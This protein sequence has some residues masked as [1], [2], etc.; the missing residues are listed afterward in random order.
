MMIFPNL[1]KIRI[2]SKI[3]NKIG[4][5]LSNSQRKFRTKYT[6]FMSHQLSLKCKQPIRILRINMLFSQVF[7]RINKTY[8][9]F[10]KCQMSLCLI[11]HCNNISTNRIS[12]NLHRPTFKIRCNNNMDIKTKFSH[13][14]NFK[15][16][17][18]IKLISNKRNLSVKISNKVF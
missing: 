8:N 16:N 5:I 9:S 7:I 14:N 3:P 18:F 10:H 12:T 4:T 15:T 1:S 13:R 2:G 11:N 17:Q 6:I